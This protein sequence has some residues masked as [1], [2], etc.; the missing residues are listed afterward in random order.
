MYKGKI[1]GV[2][3]IPTA[4]LIFLAQPMCS[5]CTNASSATEQEHAWSKVSKCGTRARRVSLQCS[6]TD[7]FCSASHPQPASPAGAMLPADSRGRTSARS[8]PAKPQWLPASVPAGA[9][10]CL[11]DDL[12]PALFSGAWHSECSWKR[13]Q[14]SHTTDALPL[15]RMICISLVLSLSDGAAD[16]EIFFLRVLSP[17]LPNSVTTCLSCDWQLLISASF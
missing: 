15:S 2:L 11:H 1:V 17:Q 12:E 8:R 10:S 9:C 16:D 6:C 7:L 3:S 13:M 14:R 4:I 5:R